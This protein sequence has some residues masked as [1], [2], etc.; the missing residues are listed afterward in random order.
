MLQN[1]SESTEINK[2]SAILH[3]FKPIKQASSP[4]KDL[5][6]QKMT[7]V[8]VISAEFDGEIRAY[9]PKF[10]TLL[11]YYD[12]K[13]EF[14]GVYFSIDSVENNDPIPTLCLRK[15]FWKRQNDKAQMFMNRDYDKYILSSKHAFVKTLFTTA[16]EVVDIIELISE[17]NSYVPNQLSVKNQCRENNAWYY[18]RVKLYDEELVFD[19][20]YC[21]LVREEPILEEKIHRWKECFMK[22]DFDNGVIPDEGSYQISYDESILERLSV[23]I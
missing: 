2:T 4:L 6:I 13:L 8:S 5:A 14:Y 3:R 23:Y 12:S 19:I 7:D 11:D 20:G 18:L 9:E 21:P 1:L 16:T 17:I 22:L 10:W 15:A